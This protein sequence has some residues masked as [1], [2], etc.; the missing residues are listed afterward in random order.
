[1]LILKENLVD[2]E[3]MT[4]DVKA[5][6]LLLELLAWVERKPRSYQETMEAWRTSCPRLS[7]WED[8]WLGNLLSLEDRVHGTRD[9]MVRLTAL[10]RSLLEQSRGSLKDSRQSNG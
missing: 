4:E 1:M 9:E 3:T 5:Y 6:P 7:V 10:G 2:I 8:A